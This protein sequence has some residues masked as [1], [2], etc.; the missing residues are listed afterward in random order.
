MKIHGKFM[1]TGELLDKGAS[2]QRRLSFAINGLF[3]LAIDK[4]PV[5]T[6]SISTYG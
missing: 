5:L 4:C 1:Q 6:E 2:T 3:D